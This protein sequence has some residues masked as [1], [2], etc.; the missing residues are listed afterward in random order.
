MFLLSIELFFDVF[1]AQ[2][3]FLLPS[4]YTLIYSIPLLVAALLLTFAGAFLTL[5]R[6]C[7]FPPQAPVEALPG[8]YDTKT[9]KK[10]KFMT[11]WR[12]EG[13]VGGLASGWGFGGEFI[14]H[15]IVSH[16]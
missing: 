14:L 12:L 6:T 15:Q 3:T 1:R 10:S 4:H 8:Q 11:W 2:V 13:G 5:C 16:Y 9:S 7:T